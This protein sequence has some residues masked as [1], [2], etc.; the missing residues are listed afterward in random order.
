MNHFI[1]MIGYSSTML[2]TEY[3]RILTQLAEQF[4]F[5]MDYVPSPSIGTHPADNTRVNWIEVELLN[6]P[7]SVNVRFANKLSELGN[8]PYDGN[9][10]DVSIAKV[11]DSKIVDAWT[12]Q[13]AY[14]SAFLV[15]EDRSPKGR[16]FF[17]STNSRLDRSDDVL[18]R[19]NKSIN[20]NKMD[21]MIH[22]YEIKEEVINGIPNTQQLIDGINKAR[23]KADAS[24][25]DPVQK[26][27]LQRLREM[28]GF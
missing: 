12:A 8:Q 6:D 1:L 4:K 13:M 19:L 15:D 20:L 16:L 7:E 14:V 11:V 5:N 24:V 23:A 25:T 22:F 3:L 26:S 9:Y 27:F 18:D 21:E 17:K 28:T 2:N 10:I